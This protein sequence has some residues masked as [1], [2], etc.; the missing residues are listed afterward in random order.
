M[1]YSISEE[2]TVCVPPLKKSE[3]GRAGVRALV[4]AAKGSAAVPV[5]EGETGRVDHSFLPCTREFSTR[6]EVM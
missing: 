6:Q 4:P 3:A 2:R 5:E 1:G